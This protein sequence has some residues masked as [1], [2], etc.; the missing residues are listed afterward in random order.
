MQ[1]YPD[2]TIRFAESKQA[3]LLAAMKR[4]AA[5]PWQWR[6]LPGE[7]PLLGQYFYFH[8]DAVGADPD[9]TVCIHV[10]G[11][12][13]WI[14][15]NVLRD[16]RT[17]IPQDRYVM[18]LREFDEQ[19]AEPAAESVGGMT[20]IDTD[21][22]SLEDYFSPRAIRLLHC[23]CKTSNVADRGAHASDQQKWMAFLLEV[24]RSTAEPVDCEVFGAC[25]EATDWWPGEYIPAL[26]LEYE[27]AMRLLR[28]AERTNG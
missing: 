3:D 21:E 26:V 8:R 5:P 1:V 15:V 7:E 2:L 11:P 19:I 27:F 28:Q 13:K 18:T 4:R 24:Y 6:D 10:Y 22:R 23:F 20:A 25:L 12:G 9:C 17:R 14:V 16:E